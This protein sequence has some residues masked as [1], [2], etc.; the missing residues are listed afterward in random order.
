VPF[1]ERFV[2][3]QAKLEKQFAAADKLTETIRAKLTMMSA[4]E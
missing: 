4:D 2:A 1:A 3:L